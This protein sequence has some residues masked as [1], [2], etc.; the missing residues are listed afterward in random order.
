MKRL[1]VFLT[2]LLGF[3]LF[4]EAKVT[5]G[6]DPV[7]P[8]EPDAH[9]LLVLTTE[10]A[11]V[12]S[13]SGGGLYMPATSTEPRAGAS[14]THR[15]VAWM[16]GDSVISTASAFPY[17]T[18]SRSVTLTA[19]FEPASSYL[20]T[21]QTNKTNAATLYG[22]GYHLPATSVYVHADPHPDYRFVA[23]KQADT[24]ISTDQGF[25]YEMPGRPA[26][27]TA[28]YV[29][30]PVNPIEPNS[31]RS[32]HTL[33][34]KS[35]P[36]RV[37][38]FS[39]GG[40]SKAP[41]GTTLNIN[42]WADQ[43]YVFRGWYADDT[44][45]SADTWL[46]YKLGAIDDTLVAKYEYNPDNQ[47]EPAVPS[48]AN[49]NLSLLSQ[50]VSTGQWAA[51]PV[52]LTNSF[53][54]VQSLMFDIAFPTGV[55]VDYPN[56]ILS[57]RKDGHTVTCDTLGGNRFRFVL[58]SNPSSYFSGSSGILLSIPVMVTD[59]SSGNRTFPVSLSN[60]VLGTTGGD[61]TCPVK[62]GA[63]L[64]KASVSDLYANFYADIF[65]NRVSFKNLSSEK[66]TSYFWDFG[67]SQTSTEKNPFHR[68]DVPGIYSTTLTVSD[69]FNQEVLQMFIEIRTPDKWR[70]EGAFTLNRELTDIRNFQ[71]AEE[72]IRL[73]SKAYI[74][75]EITVQAGVGQS[76][77]LVMSPDV[78]LYLDSVRSKL[79]RINRYL[80]FRADSTANLPALDFTSFAS[81]TDFDLLQ[82]LMKQWRSRFTTI[83]LNGI[84][85]DFWA[86]APMLYQEHC[87]G[88][89]TV[90]VD[91]ERIS[92]YLTYNW[93]Q[94]GDTGNVSGFLPSG[95]GTLPSMT[96]MNSGDVCDTVRYQVTFR[97]GSTDIL[98]ATLK[99][100]S[101]PIL[102]LVLTE[103]S[104][105]SGM[106]LHALSVGFSWKYLP[107]ALYD[108][109]LWKAGSPVPTV[110][111]VSNLSVNHYSNSSFFDYANRYYW[112]VVARVACNFMESAVDSF[113]IRTLPDLQVDSIRFPAELYAGKTVTVT[114]RITN[115]GGM[116]RDVWWQNLLSLKSD[117]DDTYMFDGQPL[118]SMLPKDSSCRVEF[119]VTLPYDTVH[120]N[121]FEV[122]TDPFGYVLESN[123][124]NNTGRSDTMHI[125]QFAMDGDE[126]QIL[127]SLYQQTD[128]ASW[129]NPWDVSK[130]LILHWNWLGVKFDKGRVTEIN[131][132]A[133][134]LKGDLPWSLFALK[135]LKTLDLSG[136]MLSGN[137]TSFADSMVAHAV[138]ADS[139][140]FLNLNYNA[141]SGDAALFAQRLPSLHSLHLYWNR[142]GVL[143]APLSSNIS[144]LDLHYQ[145]L[146]MPDFAL[147]LNPIVA[148]PP[149][150]WY[151]HGGVFGEKGALSFLLVAANRFIGRLFWDG[152]K[153]QLTWWDA[154]WDLG[155]TEPIQ[156]V[157][158]QGSL[159]G[160][161]ATVR[162]PFRMGDA[163][164]DEAVNVLDVQHTLNGLFEENPMPFNRFAAN[165][166]AD[167][168]LTV[169]DIVA[170]VNIL[171]SSVPEASVSRS[172]R[173]R[174]QLIESELSLENGELVLN[175][176]QPVS[177]LDISL[178]HLSK[179]QL[180][181]ALNSDAFSMMSSVTAEGVRFI[182]FSTNQSVLPI[183]RTV[184]AK[185]GSVEAELSGAMLSDR[186]AKELPVRIVSAS[187]DLPL[188][189]G[190]GLS[191]SYV[192]K[193]LQV[194][195]VES[196]ESLSVS[197]LNMQGRVLSKSEM[198]NVA[199]GSLVL[200]TPSSLPDGLYILQL[201]AKNG[202]VTLN[203]NVKLV[204]NK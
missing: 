183:G 25:M 190:W 126:Y 171:L 90:A 64:A 37:V 100:A 182:L 199:A 49:Y 52:Y 39:N 68:Y 136:N 32:I 77:E 185:V 46:T 59:S 35:T 117:A 40:S 16:E 197:L 65:L 181:F 141:F 27:L 119:N 85:F 109:Y 1:T 72:M 160:S 122:W 58:A 43:G 110:P 104:P 66:A 114:A 113:A 172:I 89:S 103:L 164:V 124:A 179:S 92:P 91:F 125:Q 9:Y 36:E 106:E 62:N 130:Q 167:E 38:Y 159:S 108:M 41:E 128:G 94:V 44:L 95:T 79:T 8:P 127:K 138:T 88:N 14:V 17:V 86:I 81:Q 194:L 78:N 201:R 97:M 31:V 120:Y 131:L 13:V 150:C 98:M 186:Q 170:T 47:V 75:G 55:L 30:D 10:P 188:D 121:R 15:F 42:S 3:C 102:H 193:Q 161:N 196:V 204:V 96:L 73:F 53:V 34:L 135:Q 99:L 198:M 19:K 51:Y 74:A 60:A 83:K 63:L 147:S 33:R 187:T 5:E 18:Q 165:T 148:V 123:S 153:Y 82:A 24:V 57:S 93:T 149:I 115:R 7:N 23:W 28:H 116:L 177:A 133:R 173:L 168:A 45:Y 84:P 12:A 154:S 156:L 142:I 80:N 71:D 140:R 195:L 155:P 76:F 144:A 169:Q 54:G 139:L 180:A 48:N 26:T 137:L 20:L 67:D 70:V 166:V 134:N 4:A 200:K 176:S 61:L 50:I 21:L 143:S 174:G 162:I 151:N 132:S 69:G 107:N 146:S 157:L 184:L 158:D 189:A 101:L 202:D 192:D 56:V 29:Y 152:N 175:A 112:K 6:F 87:S 2:L 111:F 178:R 191:A 203:K 118:N 11:G 145:Q 105:A 22:S 129:S 163:N